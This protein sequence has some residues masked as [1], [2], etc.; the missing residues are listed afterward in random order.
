MSSVSGNI[1]VRSDS[2]HNFIKLHISAKRP[3]TSLNDFTGLDPSTPNRNWLCRWR[4]YYN[5]LT[6]LNLYFWKTIYQ[7]Q[8][9]IINPKRYIL[10]TLSEPIIIENLNMKREKSSFPLRSWYVNLK[11]FSEIIKFSLLF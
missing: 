2:F 9:K 3:L 4:R 8:A 1:L 5:I 7:K 10:Y 6:F 11:I